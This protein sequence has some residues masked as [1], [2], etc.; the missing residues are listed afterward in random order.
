MKNI[1]S[2]L[3]LIFIVIGTLLLG[4]I[5][6]EQ[7]VAKILSFGY[8]GPVTFLFLILY[9]TVA[10]VLAIMSKKM[11]YKALLLVLST[12]LLLFSIIFTFVGAFAFQSP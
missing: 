11:K 9:S 8:L 7:V 5:L 3:S 6:N 10:F 2:A 1:Y 4:S 12:I